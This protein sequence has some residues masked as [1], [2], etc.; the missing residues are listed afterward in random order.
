M[1]LEYNNKMK[2]NKQK[3]YN[4]LPIKQLSKNI[5]L[6]CVLFGLFI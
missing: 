4:I 3:R 1:K 2:R 6:R 5:Y